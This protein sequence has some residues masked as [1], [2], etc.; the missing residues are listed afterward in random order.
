MKMG[1]FLTLIGIITLLLILGFFTRSLLFR[2]LRKRMP[3]KRRKKRIFE[4]IN[5]W[6]EHGFNYNK[7]LELLIRQGYDKS[8]ANILLG[9]VEYMSKPIRD[10]KTEESSEEF[11]G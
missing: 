2:Y 4:Q 6:K 3:G 10:Q 9:E 8:V 7:R 5:L 11:I 1:G